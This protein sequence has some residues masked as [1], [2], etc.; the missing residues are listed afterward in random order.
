MH[1]SEQNKVQS[2]I[3]FTNFERERK[4]HSCQWVSLLL[5]PHMHKP[6][7]N[8]HICALLNGETNCSQESIIFILLTVFSRGIFTLK[9]L[10]N[11]SR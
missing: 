7:H 9:A 3:S 11:V 2:R 6:D 10:E 5:N 8:K 4:F 1:S